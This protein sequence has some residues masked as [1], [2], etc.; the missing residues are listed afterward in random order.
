MSA[1]RRIAICADDFGMSPGVSQ[2]IAALARAGRI[3]ATSCLAN[4]AHWR[5]TAPMLADLPA[6]IDVGLHFNLTEG[7]PL[8]AEMRTHWAQMPRLPS[9]IALAHL[10]A[11]PLAAVA[12]EFAAQ[13]AA[14]VDAMGRAPA[15]IDGHQ[16]VHHLPGIREVVLAALAKLPADVAV[17]NTGRVAGPGFGV[18]RALIAGTGGLALARRLIERGIAH[19]AVLIGA[20][21]FAPGAYRDWMKGWFASVPEDGALLFCHP[22]APDASGVVDPIAAARGPEAAYLA[23]AAFADDLM[24]AQLSIGRV[25]RRPALRG[26]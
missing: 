19:N 20:Y 23:S 3:N 14:F 2:G 7:E 5:A 26:P 11:V 18:K 16:H 24:E 4:A 21:D 8:C 15:F 22:G 10:R 25:W 13:L 6:S 17:R 12:A 1:G 9:L